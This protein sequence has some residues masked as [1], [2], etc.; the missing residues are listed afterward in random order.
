MLAVAI[1][2]LNTGVFQKAITVTSSSLS[3][4]VWN[5]LTNTLAI[6]LPAFH[7]RTE[8]LFATLY[9]SG[10]GTSWIAIDG[11]YRVCSDSNNFYIQ[12]VNPDNNS[13]NAWL[14]LD[15]F[16]YTTTTKTSSFLMNSVDILATFASKVASTIL[17][18]QQ[19]KMSFSRTRVAT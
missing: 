12:R 13:I 8:G 5:S 19:L 6:D 18:Q 11:F 7:R 14:N 2:V 3:P 9:A 15:T 10:T 1:Y 16:G 17:I 4:L